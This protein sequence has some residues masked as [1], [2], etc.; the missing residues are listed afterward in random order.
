MCAPGP[1]LRILI[2]ALA[3]VLVLL[4]CAPRDGAAPSPRRI[5]LV[6]MD[7]VRADRVPGV[8][9]GALTPELTRLAEKGAVFRQFHAASNY[10]LPSTMSMMTGLDPLEHG[11]VVQAA[12]LAP[13]VPT[14]AERLAQAGYRTASF[15][16][17]GYVGS[18]YGFDRGFGIYRELPPQA[19]TGR[20]LDEVLAWIDARGAEE[21]W[22]L[23]LHTYTAHFPY[24]GYAR[25]RARHPERGLLSDER[26][27]ELRAR[28][29][30]TP[31]Q[32][33]RA[34]DGFRASTRALCT[35]YNQLAV[36]YQDLLGCGHHWLP[37]TFHESPHY[38]PS[39]LEAVRTSY[40]DR[41]RH[42]DRALGR[43]R[44]RLQARGLWRDTLV[45]VTSD[46]GEGFFEHGLYMHDYSPFE[47]VLRVPLL[48]SWPAG[49]PAA[50]GRLVEVPAWHLDL[51]PTVLALAGLDPGPLPGLDLS[52]WLGAD[53]PE[54]P[55]RARYPVALSAPNQERRPA[56]RVVLYEGRKWIEGH[57]V[58]GD[59][60]GLLFDLRE[61]PGEQRNLRTARPEEAARGAALA[62]AYERGLVLRP[63]VNSDTG[64]R[65]PAPFA[66][67]PPALSK[68]ERELLSGLG[69]LE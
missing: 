29:P 53:P 51:V 26:I 23:F 34:A 30:W 58:F 18:R 46:H 3:A 45:V 32:L 63:P 62:A 13:E 27:R 28:A 38:R 4:T 56:R 35:V 59:G 66:A 39:D 42:I 48:I 40:D 20:S 57:P 55:S 31:G 67:G 36:A 41:V 25:Y 7:T 21:P 24:G 33:G 50:R 15:N 49:L 14:L 5:L 19:V 2:P 65:I 44:E 12:R 17:S 6:S 10:T 8:G 37:T 60:E 64:E 47:E 1:R 11:V 16:E 61:D 52:P 22:F 68:E 9:S 43:V 54:A 69:Y